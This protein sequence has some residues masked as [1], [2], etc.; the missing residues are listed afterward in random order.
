MVM[1]RFRVRDGISHMVNNSHSPL[2]WSISAAVLVKKYLL[3][4][5]L[6]SCCFPLVSQFFVEWNLF[7][8][9]GDVFNGS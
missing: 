9:A 8:S 1:V 4:M 5:M 7:V 6:L 3:F 2:D